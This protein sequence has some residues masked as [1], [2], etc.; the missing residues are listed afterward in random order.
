MSSLYISAAKKSSG[1]TSISIGICAA[2]KEKGFKVQTFKKGPDYIDPLWLSQASGQP[3][4]NLDFHTMSPEE[5]LATFVTKTSCS[6]FN[7][8]EGNKGLFDGIDVEGKFSNAELSAQLKTPVVLVLDTE[9]MTRGIAPLLLG[10]LNFDK[11]IKITGIILN[12]VGGIRH[13]KKLRAAIEYYT[14]VKIFGA[15]Q[16]NRN[17]IIDERHLGLVPSNEMRESTKLINSICQQ[18]SSEVD[19]D[20]LINLHKPS[21]ITEKKDISFKNSKTSLKKIRIGYAK[22]SAFGFY[23]ASDLMALES[24]GAE[25]IPFSPITDKILPNVDGIFIGGGFPET[26]LEKLEGNQKI[27]RQIKAFIENGGPSYAECGGLMYL[28]RK[29]TWNKQQSEMLG[30]IPADIVMHDHPKGRGYVLLNELDNHPWPSGAEIPGHE[31]HYSTMENLDKNVKF[32]YKVE[33]GFG[34][35][36]NNDGVLVNNLL[37]SYSHL[38]D[39]SKNRWASRF[40]EYVRKHKN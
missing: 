24:A 23:Y 35:D 20:L 17:I 36:G 2:L 1:K 12:K 29:I 18:I 30:I 15:V 37:A 4:F 22:D 16:R 33:R 40:V 39:T 10:H 3:C 31:F 14:D 19:L 25:I 34:V 5:I 38:R 27:G 26:N 13:E 28:C 32:A 8:I 21:V 11:Q 7:L 9:G 6:N